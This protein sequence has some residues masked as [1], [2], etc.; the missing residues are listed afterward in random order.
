MEQSFFQ[1]YCQVYNIDNPEVKDLLLKSA[2]FTFPPAYI[3]AL[4]TLSGLNKESCSAACGE[5]KAEMCS[6]IIQLGKDFMSAKG[7]MKGMS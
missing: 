5:R 1:D 2:S 7:P 6:M 3:K 4:R